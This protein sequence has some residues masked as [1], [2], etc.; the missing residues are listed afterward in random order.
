[1]ST[2]EK[3]TKREAKNLIN[4]LELIAVRLKI[5]TFTKKAVFPF[6]AKQTRKLHILMY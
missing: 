3:K 6:T 4:I 5:L 2:G 1:M